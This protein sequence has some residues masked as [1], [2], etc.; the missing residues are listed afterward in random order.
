MIGLGRRAARAAPK[1]IKDGGKRL[2]LSS[3]AATTFAASKGG[4]SVAPCPDRRQIVSL[5]SARPRCVPVPLERPAFDALHKAAARREF[6]VVMV[7]CVNR[8]GRSVQD[9]VSFLNHRPSL[10]IQT[11]PFSYS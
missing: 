6:D 10:M 3:Y 1:S 11:T 7:W 5:S 9:L 8:L 4:L 2:L